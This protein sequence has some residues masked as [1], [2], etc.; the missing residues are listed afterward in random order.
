MPATQPRVHARGAH[1]VHA[2]AVRGIGGCI[3][4][5]ALLHATVV[6]QMPDG[7]IAGTHI[8]YGVGIARIARGRIAPVQE[9]FLIRAIA[10]H[11]GKF[12]PD[13]RAAIGLH[14]TLNLIRKWRAICLQGNTGVG[15][16]GFRPIEIE[17][18]GVQGNRQRKVPH[19]TRD[20]RSLN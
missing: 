3:T 11:E 16:V 9:Q 13:Q 12:D 14:P 8:E 4:I 10:A 5:S 2:R 20:I 1:H 7:H 17:I 6:S 18:V 19:V 15:A